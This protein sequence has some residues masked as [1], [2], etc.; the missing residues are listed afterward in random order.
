MSQQNEPSRSIEIVPVARHP[1]VLNTVAGWILDQWGS[2]PIEEISESLRDNRDCPPTLIAM[3]AGQAIGV[4]SYRTYRLANRDTEDLWINALY[5][6]KPQRGKGVGA[7]LVE[8]GVK[9]A[10]QE[11]SCR[12][13]LY[14]YTDIPIFYEQ[15]GWQRVDFNQQTEMHILEHWLQ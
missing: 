13:S 2:S 8:A 3:L 10:K 9:A 11:A 1:Q 12:K 15:L 5:V 7:R 4:L 14:V 6:A